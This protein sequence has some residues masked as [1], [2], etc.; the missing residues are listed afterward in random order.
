MNYNK[1]GLIELISLINSKEIC[2]I[3]INYKDRLLRFGFEIIEELCKLN[4]VTIDIINA[5]EDKTYEQ[6]L[7]DDVLSIITAYSSKLYGS[8][9]QTRKKFIEEAKNKLF[10]E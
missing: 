9:T 5:T 3:V 1:I 8:K 4:N 10:N 6:E 2:K 7:V